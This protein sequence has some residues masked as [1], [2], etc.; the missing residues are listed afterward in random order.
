ML[1]KT[2]RLLKKKDF[3]RVFKRGEGYGDDFLIPSREK[4]Q[5]PARDGLFF[6]KIFKNNFGINRFGII[7]SQKVSKNATIRNKIKRQISEIIRLE[8]PKIKKGFDIILLTK[9]RVGKESFIGLK[10]KLEK[11]FEKAK[12]IKN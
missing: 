12:L 10:T 11:V 4:K 1:S 6:L 2:N 3:N 7:V 9:P 8:M 5:S